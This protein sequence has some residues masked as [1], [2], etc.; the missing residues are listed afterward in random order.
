VKFDKFD[1]IIL[2]GMLLIC[3]GIALYSLPLA[4]IAGGISLV[5]IGLLGAT[6]DLRR[7]P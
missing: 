3:G 1:A 7:N 4:L 5:I 2:A 6:A